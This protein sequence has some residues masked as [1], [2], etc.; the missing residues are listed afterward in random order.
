MSIVAVEF[1]GRLMFVFAA[2]KR[3]EDRQPRQPT[4]E[5]A[6]WLGFQANA[7]R[8]RDCSSASPICSFSRNNITAIRYSRP[9]GTTEQRLR[10]S[11]RR[12][13]AGSWPRVLVL[14]VYVY[15]ADCDCNDMPGQSVCDLISSVALASRPASSSSSHTPLLDVH[16]HHQDHRPPKVTHAAIRPRYFSTRPTKS[17]QA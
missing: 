7:P 2:T 3:S 5:R 15:F 11:Q 9:S 17:T 6:G 10:K 8:R 16:H 13:F 4:P 12:K 14:A 1:R